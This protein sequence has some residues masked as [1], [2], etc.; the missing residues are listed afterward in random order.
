MRILVFLVVFG[1]L[2]V[3]M[4]IFATFVGEISKKQISKQALDIGHSIAVM[5]SVR[6]ILAAGEDPDGVLQGVAEQVREKTGARFIVIADARSIRYSH[7]NPKR[8]GKPFVGGDE[9]LALETGQAYVSEAVG[10]LGPSLRSIV[11]VLDHQGKVLGFV[12]VGYLQARVMEI[13]AGHQ[14][15]PATLVFMLFVVVLLGATG[16]AKFVKKPDPGA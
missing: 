1:S 2:F 10:T 4:A 9:A 11:P 5:P 13:V 8:I 15:E 3:S 7:P 14:R 6:T 16:I 12:S